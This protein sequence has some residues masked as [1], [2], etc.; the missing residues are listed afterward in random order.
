H[1]RQRYTD[2]ARSDR[3]CALPERDRYFFG[4][5]G[6]DPIADPDLV[7]VDDLWSGFVFFPAAIVVTVSTAM[8]PSAVSM[9]VDSSVPFGEEQ[10]VMVKSAPDRQA[11]AAH[12]SS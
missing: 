2:A 3:P 8:A 11:R 6:L 7:E 10:A 9:A 1:W 5:H 4:Q 12:F